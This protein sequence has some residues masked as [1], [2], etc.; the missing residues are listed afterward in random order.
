VLTLAKTDG[1]AFYKYWALAGLGDLKKK[2]G[3]LAGALKAYYESLAIADRLAKSGPG[4]AG[5][6]RNL[7]VSYERV[8]DVQKAQGDLV[9]RATIL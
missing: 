2:R 4:N 7:S 5:W 8:G 1:Q 3:D 6:Q 9:C